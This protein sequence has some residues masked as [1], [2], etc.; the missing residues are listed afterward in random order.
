MKSF[1][2]PE[3]NLNKIILSAIPLIVLMTSCSI[4]GNEPELPGID[5]LKVI[6]ELPDPFLMNNGKRVR[7]RA[8]W[9]KRRKEIKAM[10]QYYQY[11]HMP[12][13]PGNITAR[14]LSREEIY[15]GKA[16]KKH[17][18]LSMGPDKNIIINLGIIMPTGKGPFPVII[19]NAND[20]FYVPI[21]EEIVKRGYVV[22]EYRRTD[23][24][25]DEN[26]II[27]P[28]QK[29]YPDHDW[30]TLAVWAWGGMRVIDYLTTLDYI[31]KRYI[32]F[33]GHSRGGK[34]ALLAGALDERITLVAPNGSGCGGAGCYRIQGKKSETLK[35]IT[36]PTR[37]SYWFHP[38][39]RDFV[40]Q[41]TKLPF[42]QHFLKALV[43][44]RALISIDALGDLWANPL[45][46]Q[47]TYLAAQPVFDFLNA[48]NKN[49]IHFRQGGHDQNEEDWHTLVD[50]A[51]M[52]FFGKKVKRKFD[53]LPFPDAQ[54]PFSWS[55][56]PKNNS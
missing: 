32:A 34:T 53:Q 30:A 19:K 55:T 31:D 51:D 40:N 36:E 15:D 23:L 27:G 50:F 21:A 52:V 8:D 9:E 49:A 35:D 5:K 11:G 33:T 44:P 22:A 37:F 20:I 42:D 54:N 41:E 12:A 13:A 46:T 14:E 16:L 39:F 26:N 7:T 18:L 10:I 3:T 1:P 48:G 47:Q 6:E 38:R 25:P 28:A 56:P 45:G 2:V 24:D 4:T 29:A 17:L 43:A